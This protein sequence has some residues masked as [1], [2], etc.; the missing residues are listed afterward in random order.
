MRLSTLF[1]SLGD[2]VARFYEENLLDTHIV[3]IDIIWIIVFDVLV[4]ID[5][6]FYRLV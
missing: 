6:F 2:L 4:E 3:R 5:H 1:K